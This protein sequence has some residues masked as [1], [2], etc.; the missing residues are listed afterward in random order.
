MF[1]FKKAPTAFFDSPSSFASALKALAGM[2][3]ETLDNHLDASAD[4]TLRKSTE[5]ES[6]I[7]IDAA[8]LLRESGFGLVARHDSMGSFALF[9]KL[10]TDC[11]P[12]ESAWSRLEKNE[13][14]DACETPAPRATQSL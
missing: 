9:Y 13:I 8:R 7:D 14:C 3:G 4:L 5:P 10:P 11:G 6:D 12:Y 2:S 1:A